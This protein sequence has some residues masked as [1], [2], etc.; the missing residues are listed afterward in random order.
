MP[1]IY[2]RVAMHAIGLDDPNELGTD[3]FMLHDTLIS[4]I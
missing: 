2:R 1:C 3:I 4:T